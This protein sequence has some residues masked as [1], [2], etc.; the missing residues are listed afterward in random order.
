MKRANNNPA[1][2]GR[3]FTMRETAEITGLTEHT[4]RYYEKVGL[5]TRVR[6]D[7]A[8]GH[9]RY[10]S[11]DLARI[12]A[13]SC[14]RMI[15]M[16]IEDMR[17]YGSLDFEDKKNFAEL[18]AILERQ[19]DVLERRKAEM[20]ETLR[21]VDMK[22]GYLAAIASGDEQQISAAARRMKKTLD[23]IEARAEKI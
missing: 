1:F 5:L 11:I 15:G 7:E 3:E 17:R 10:S 13:L 18:M 19:R 21:Y 12:E 2:D 8:S 4:L 6:R 9:R 14:L 16:P 23:R 20:D 22:T